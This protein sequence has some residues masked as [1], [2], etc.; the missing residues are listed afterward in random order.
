MEMII[1]TVFATVVVLAAAFACATVFWA[2]TRISREK[3]NPELD[4]RRRMDLEE[5]EK[6]IS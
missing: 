3:Q 4:N 2:S 5:L 6:R 1:R